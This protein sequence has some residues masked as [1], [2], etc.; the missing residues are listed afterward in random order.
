MNKISDKDLAYCRGEIEKVL[1]KSMVFPSITAVAKAAGLTF[2][3]TKLMLERFPDLEQKRKDSL[4]G[5]TGMAVENIT[6]VL[7]DE[8]NPNNFAA[9]KMILSKFKS[10]LDEVL[11]TKDTLTIGAGQGITVSIGEEDEEE[12]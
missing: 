3:R 7:K 8:N 2:D 9:S 11:E 4:K 10:E 1:K 6:N 12:D 5:L